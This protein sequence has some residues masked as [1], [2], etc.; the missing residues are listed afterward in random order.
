MNEIVRMRAVEPVLYGVLKIVWADGYEAVVDLRP[1]I[2]TGDIFRFLRAEPDRF[3]TVRLEEHGNSI[4]WIDHDG[5]EID[6]GAAALRRRA[7]EQD[8]MHRLAG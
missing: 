1:V 6:F 5:D 4:Y 7:K 8:E 3:M 2:G